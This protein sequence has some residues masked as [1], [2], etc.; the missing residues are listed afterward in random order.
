MIDTV[1]SYPTLLMRPYTAG[2]MVTQLQSFTTMMPVEAASM[3]EQFLTPEML[4]IVYQMMHD[5]E[6][7]DNVALSIT[8]TAPLLPEIVPYAHEIILDSIDEV[9]EVSDSASTDLSIANTQPETEPTIVQESVTLIHNYYLDT[10][11]T[12]MTPQGLADYLGFKRKQ[13]VTLFKMAKRTQMTPYEFVHYITSKILPNKLYAS[14][15][16][17]QQKQQ[18][19][20]LQHRMDAAE[21]ER[22]SVPAIEQIAINDTTTQTS[23]TPKET[24]FEPI[25]SN[26]TAH[27]ATIQS[28]DSSTS[29]SIQ[30]APQ[31]LKPITPILVPQQNTFQPNNPQAKASIAELIDFITHDLINDPDLETFIPDSLKGQLSQIENIMDEGL[32]QIRGNGRSIAAIVTNYP[33]EGTDA[34]HF[35]QRLRNMCNST[36]NHEYN[37][38]GEMVMFE[39]MRQGFGRELLMVTLL[40]IIA[41]CIIVAITFHSIV[42]PIILI[43]IVLSGVYINVYV[44]GLGGGNLLYLAYLI[45]QSILMGATIDYAILFSNYY[46]EHRRTQEIASSLKEAYRGSIHTITTSGLIIVCAPGVMS[47]LVEDRTIAMIVSC[48]AV[49]GAAAILLILFV[50]PGVL[51]ALDRFVIPKKN[52]SQKN[53]TI[54]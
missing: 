8:N 10:I 50:L 28:S 41:I 53:K 39:E 21:A 34:Q 9:A 17:Q 18:L 23:P 22:L 36:L 37:L 38:I 35:L 48:L 3:V 51:A 20:A 11:H 32:G 16:S 43:L 14:F 52:S 46:R 29:S 31:D 42:V 33:D 45:V 27:S 25:D 40:T 5:Q 7:V 2:E 26:S 47:L 15:I 54:E 24:L 6:S 19:L 13:A 1:I 44:S 4:D 49:G 12:P 30:P